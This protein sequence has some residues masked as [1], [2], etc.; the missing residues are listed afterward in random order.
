MA[1][2]ELNR[3]ASLTALIPLWARALE[4]QSPKPLFDDTEARR[5]WVN[6][7]YIRSKSNIITE[8]DGVTKKL[9]QTEIAIRTDI[10]DKL[11]R[12]KDSEDGSCTFVN[13]GSGLCTRAKRTG[14]NSRFIETDST[15]GLAFR[16][17]ILGLK[18]AGEAQLKI[19]LHD[20][21]PIGYVRERTGNRPL[22]VICEGTLMY[23]KR[24]KAL[25]LIESLVKLAGKGGTVIAEILGKN[26]QGLIHPMVKRINPELRYNWGT[27]G[28]KSLA[29]EGF[30]ITSYHDVWEGYEKKWGPMAHLI[31]WWPKGRYSFGSFIVEIAGTD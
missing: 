2:K 24:D 21:V 19:D 31:K 18:S 1:K 9:T 17:K 11:A 4:A 30:E 14:L 29:K 10:I 12:R 23:F 6:D 27:V 13:I 15:Q 5:L 8:T 25:S 20:P 3:D 16:N 26:G 22:T 28:P 7:P